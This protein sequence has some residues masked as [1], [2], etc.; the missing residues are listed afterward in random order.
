MNEVKQKTPF[1]VLHQFSKDDSDLYQAYLRLKYEVFVEEQG[2][3]SL[4]HDTKQKIAREDEFDA[5]G[6]FW[7]A[8]AEETGP[9]GIVRG[10]PLNE[11]FP[12][13]EL[14]KHHLDQ[15]KFAAMFE[16]LGTINGLAVRTSYRRHCYRVQEWG[17]SGT[18][19]RLL[20]LAIVRSLETE[21]LEAAIATTG[22]LISTQLCE[23]LGFVAIDLPQKTPLHPG[24]IMMNIGLVFGSL[25]HIRAQQECGILCSGKHPL[26]PQ[27]AKLLQYF[28]ERRTTLLGDKPLK[29]I[30]KNH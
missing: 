30:L 29:E 19:G 7:I 24:I 2:W 12:H 6:R 23:S 11:G 13:R 18:I 22:G 25:P 21:G 15:P 3:H 17:W 27:A 10:I 9:V 1:I 20:M 14:F 16:N 4:A 5:Q 8:I 26:R 28:E